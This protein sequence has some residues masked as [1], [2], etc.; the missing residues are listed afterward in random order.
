MLVCKVQIKKAQG[1]KA[2]S[3]QIHPSKNTVFYKIYKQG[4]ECSSTAE[5][6]REGHVVA[7]IPEQ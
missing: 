4:S 1:Q 3:R 2:R 6:P 7:H 5:S